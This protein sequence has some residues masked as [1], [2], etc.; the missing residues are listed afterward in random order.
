MLDKER[1]GLGFTAAGHNTRSLI[2]IIF[3]GI[4]PLLNGAMGVHLIRSSASE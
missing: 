3:D 4:L 2:W 1:I